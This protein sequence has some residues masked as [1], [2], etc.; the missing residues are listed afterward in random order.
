VNLDMTD[1][2]HLLKQAMMTAHDY[3]HSAVT[4]IDECFGRGY[5]EKNP[6]FVAAYMHVAAR[7]FDTAMRVKYGPPDTHLPD[8]LNEIANA[9]RAVAKK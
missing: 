1:D 4:D 3:M 8:A 5:A 6:N 9:I 2:D 7:D